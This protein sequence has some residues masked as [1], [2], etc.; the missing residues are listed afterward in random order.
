MLLVISSDQF[1]YCKAEDLKVSTLHFFKHLVLI[2]H[3]MC[4]EIKFLL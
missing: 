4:I 2:V 3:N 1:L